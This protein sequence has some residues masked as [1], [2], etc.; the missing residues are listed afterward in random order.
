[1]SDATVSIT[2]A[3]ESTVSRHSYRLT[4]QGANG[5]PLAGREVTVR[6]EGDG[7]LAPTFDAK[8]MKR[9]TDDEGCLLITWYRRGI[10]TRGV[11]AT[12]TVLAPDPDVVVSLERVT[13]AP[14][15]GGTWI[16]YPDRPIR[17]SPR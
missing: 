6:I 15:E 17:I 2:E 8:E 10:F 16:S 12:L 14:G 13:E 5:E 4:L 9:E 3:F 11:K 1:M 7:S